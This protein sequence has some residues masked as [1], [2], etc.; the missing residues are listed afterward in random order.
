M[1]L[2]NFYSK[3]CK[4]PIIM[5]KNWL[6]QILTNIRCWKW[7]FGAENGRKSKI[8]SMK[9]PSKIFL[10]NIATLYR[11][12]STHKGAKIQLLGIKIH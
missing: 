10:H 2:W 12:I 7:S 9:H 3:S 1:T 4:N 6:Y 8:L 11:Q 5:D